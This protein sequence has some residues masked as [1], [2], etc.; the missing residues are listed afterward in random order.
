[1]AEAGPRDFA[2]WGTLLVT[3]FAI[4]A[5]CA[6]FENVPVFVATEATVTLMFASIGAVLLSGAALVFRRRQLQ[7]SGFG[8]AL[9]VEYPFALSLAFIAFWVAA[10]A[11][12]VLT[13]GALTLK[14]SFAGLL[15]RAFVTAALLYFFAFTFGRTIMTLLTLVRAR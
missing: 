4:I 12:L 9:K 11:L 13:A 2:A 6:A 5:L 15:A 8:E 1:M 7:S 10:F 14:L 3:P